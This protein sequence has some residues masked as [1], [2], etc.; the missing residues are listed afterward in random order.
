MCL[1]TVS[2]LGYTF[3]FGWRH[4]VAG[5][6]HNTARRGELGMYVTFLASMALLP[7]VSK[8]RAAYHLFKY[9]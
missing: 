2:E 7:K 4:S 1:L 9:T 6:L 3:H 8:D 5:K